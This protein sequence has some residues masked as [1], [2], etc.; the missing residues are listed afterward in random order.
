M[1]IARTAIILLVFTFAQESFGQTDQMNNTTT[2]PAKLYAGKTAE[3]WISEVIR[4]AVTVRA[5]EEDYEQN[6]RECVK[7]G[8][9]K[10]DQAP[11]CIRA[12][13]SYF[14]SQSARN[15]YQRLLNTVSRTTL[16]VEWLR[17]NFT[18]VR[19]GPEWKQ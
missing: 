11:P 14:A 12:N 19:F 13:H 8:K 5:T 1:A 15:E 10:E 9:T 2:A 18:W 17:A 3:H 7:Q 16:P 6:L 4:L